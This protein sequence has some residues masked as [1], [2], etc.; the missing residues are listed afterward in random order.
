MARHLS[1]TLKNIFYSQPWK[2]KK[3]FIYTLRCE[4]VQI[5]GSNNGSHNKKYLST[6]FSRRELWK[7][8]GN[9]RTL[10]YFLLTSEYSNRWSHKHQ[11]LIDF[12]SLPLNCW[13]WSHYIN[14]LISH[15]EKT[16]DECSELNEIKWDNQK[17]KKLQEE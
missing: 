15:C 9:E 7:R 11:L 3:T 5:P 10:N 8:K 1:K 16:F 13:Y 6:E 2:L 4:N 12:P 17:V 14:I